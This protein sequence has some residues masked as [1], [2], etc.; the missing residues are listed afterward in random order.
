MERMKI[1][2]VMVVLLVV[3][4][5]VLADYMWRRWMA[6]RRRDHQ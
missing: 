1:V 4:G 2:L 3:A 6:D 5:S